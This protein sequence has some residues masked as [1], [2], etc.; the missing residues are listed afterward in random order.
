M[1]IIL[2]YNYIFG[3]WLIVRL[4]VFWIV[5]RDLPPKNIL[6]KNNKCAYSEISFDFQTE[7]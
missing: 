2:I 7:I 4:E 3:D 5:L 6:N 1:P